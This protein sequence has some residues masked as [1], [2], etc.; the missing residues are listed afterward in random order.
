M[1][2]RDSLLKK[3][4]KMKESAFVFED[5]V[6]PYTFFPLIMLKIVF[7]F[8][9]QLLLAETPL[10]PAETVRCCFVAHTAFQ[11]GQSTF[12]AQLPKSTAACDPS[13]PCVCGY[14]C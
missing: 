13:R 12:T 10:L 6:S 2:E 14:P 5:I 4:G 7:L 11:R 3:V 8:L 9:I 1:F